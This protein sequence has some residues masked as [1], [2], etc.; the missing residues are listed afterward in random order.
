MSSQNEK[1]AAIAAARAAAA[2]AG[3]VPAVAAAKA[4]ASKKASAPLR[5]VTTGIAAPVQDEATKT[6]ADVAAA[7]AAKAHAKAERNADRAERAKARDAAKLAKD[8]RKQK[9]AD[10]RKEQRALKSKGAKQTAEDKARLAELKVEAHAV[11]G[12]G[13][14]KPRLLN[15]LGKVER[16]LAMMAREAGR[17]TITTERGDAFDPHAV[18]LGLGTSTRDAKAMVET[19]EV[20]RKVKATSGRTGAAAKP[21]VVAGSTVTVKP[22]FF[23]TYEDVLNVADKFTVTKVVGKRAVVVDSEGTKSA[24]PLAHLEVA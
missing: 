18:L 24:L 23:D 11:R 1:F 5:E 16:L 6:D 4:A 21:K 22:K 15:L 2:K 3:T 10:I 7:A 20:T 12:T 17:Y 19:S 14:G 8:I 13:R 9:L